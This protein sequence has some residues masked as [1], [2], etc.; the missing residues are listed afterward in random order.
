MPLETAKIQVS[1]DGRETS[2]VHEKKNF[3]HYLKVGQRSTVDSDRKDAD[4][5]ILVTYDVR[6]TANAKRNWIREKIKRY[7]G[8]WKNDSTYLVPKSVRSV[9]DIRQWGKDADVN[10]FVLGMHTD[11]KLETKT[12]TQAY[13]GKLLDDI[14]EI[15]DSAKK[16]FN[17]LQIIEE[18]IELSE[19]ELKDKYNVSFRGFHNVVKSTRKRSTDIEEMVQNY[20]NNDD[21]FQIQMLYTFIEKLETRFER[22]KEAKGLNK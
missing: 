18:H 21:E 16:S 20:G 3:A 9:D 2:I 15:R 12:L 1:K 13:I 19:E 5:W 4:S 6:D 10:L 17:V 7:G 14:K 22:I 11:D 8:L